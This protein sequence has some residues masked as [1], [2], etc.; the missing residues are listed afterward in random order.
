VVPLE[1]SPLPTILARGSFGMVLTYFKRYRM[2]INLAR[3]EVQ[4]P[5]LADGFR[6]IPWDL[7]MLDIHADVKYRCFRAE[8]DSDVFP[9]LGDYAGCLRLMREISRKQGFLP[10]ATWLLRYED[11]RTAEIDYCG[12]IQGIRDKRGFGAIQ[13]VGIT[14]EYRGL[15]LGTAMLQRCLLGFLSTGVRRVSLEVTAQNDGAIA[16]Y[17]RLGFAKCRTVYKAVDTACA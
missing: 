3:R 14:P 1:R 4:R 11:P 15:G 7:L 10:K 9:C 6:L 16:L 13:N 17:R 5:S 8:V 12:T 2:E